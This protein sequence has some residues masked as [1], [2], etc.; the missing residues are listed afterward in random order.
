MSGGRSAIDAWAG[1]SESWGSQMVFAFT[2]GQHLPDKDRKKSNE[3]FHAG[4]KK[5]DRLR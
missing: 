2:D 5:C 1:G 3:M 4:N